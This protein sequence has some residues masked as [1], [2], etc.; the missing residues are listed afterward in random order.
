MASI[1]A[2]R[3][4]GGTSPPA[5]LPF[6]RPVTDVVVSRCDFRSQLK[7]AMRVYPPRSSP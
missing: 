3:S 1:V 6:L 2:V 7:T 5:T 4:R